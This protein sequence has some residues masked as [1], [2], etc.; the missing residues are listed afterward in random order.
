MEA[1]KAMET[2]VERKS[3]LELVVNR[4]VNAPARLVWEA[5]KWV[6]ISLAGGTGSTTLNVAFA[7]FKELADKKG[8]VFD[9]DLQALVSEPLKPVMPCVVMSN[10]IHAYI[11]QSDKGELV[12]GASTDGYNSYSQA[13]SLHVA[14]H[15]IEAICELF[16]TFRRV[17][18]LRMP[19]MPV[20][21]A[22]STASTSRRSR[23]SIRTSRTRFFVPQLPRVYSVWT[24]I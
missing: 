14:P 23:W 17:R 1:S 4:T 11:S 21:R 5:W 13:G 20:T 24:F 6:S 15:T 22:G 2:K 8:E 7:K 12:I 18:M 16:P 19:S 9:E 10:A 3:N